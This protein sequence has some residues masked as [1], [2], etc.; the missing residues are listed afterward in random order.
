[1]DK[2]IA[3]LMSLNYTGDHD[4]FLVIDFPCFI[5]AVEKIYLWELVLVHTLVFCFD[6][7]LHLIKNGTSC[8]LIHFLTEVR[9]FHTPVTRTE[10]MRDVIYHLTFS[11]FWCMLL[12]VVLSVTERTAESRLHS[13][14]ILLVIHTKGLPL[15]KWMSHIREFC[16]NI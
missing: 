9:P 4:R 7:W 16:I 15:Y 3:L 6:T 1:M 14:H 12:R 10:R 11:C 2:W 13:G 5:S 8:S